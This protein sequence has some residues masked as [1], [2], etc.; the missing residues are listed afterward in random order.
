VHRQDA[1]PVI[2]ILPEFAGGDQGGQI[3]VGGGNEPHIHGDGLVAAHTLKSFVFQHP[4]Q[5]RLDLQGNL[6]DFVEENGAAVGLFEPADTLLVGAGKRPFF[7]AE[8]FASKSVSGMLAQL[9]L[10]KGRSLRG[11]L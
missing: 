1:D 10:M 6:T 7:M 11:E 9:I 5:F 3:F 8:K 2:E 4:Q